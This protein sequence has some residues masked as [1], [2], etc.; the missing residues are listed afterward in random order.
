MYLINQSEVVRYE[1][2]AA[3]E[4]IDGVSEGIDCFHVQV[5]GRLIEQQQMRHLPSQPGKHNSTTLTIGQL[6]NRTNLNTSVSD[7]Y[8]SFLNII[9]S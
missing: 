6:T 1:N 2:H 8:S 9:I 7:Y 3:I 5:I 4:I